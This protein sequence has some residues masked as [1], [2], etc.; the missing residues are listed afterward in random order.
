[1]IYVIIYY[2]RQIN[3]TAVVDGP[4]AIIVFVTDSSVIG[5][6]FRLTYSTFANITEDSPFSY[7][8]VHENRPTENNFLLMADPNEILI[9]AYSP[10]IIRNLQVINTDTSVKIPS[11]R[12]QI[13]E[14]CNSDTLTIYDVLGRDHGLVV[15]ERFVAENEN[16][17]TTT[18]LTFES[19]EEREEETTTSSVTQCSLFSD[20][21]YK[22]CDNILDCGDEPPNS[23]I[24][25]T[26]TTSFVAIYKSVNAT[27]SLRFRGAI[28]SS[29]T[30]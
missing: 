27:G 11:F 6:G 24:M 5:D 13:D 26:N 14:H 9:A 8:L 12:P 15:K 30:Q 2:F 1:M 10:E 25:I 21:H 7:H 4:V 19:N 18:E 29:K 20:S 28:I 17:S 23:S 3:K 22:P 16:I